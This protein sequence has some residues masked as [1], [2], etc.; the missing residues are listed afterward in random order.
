MAIGV[1]GSGLAPR[2]KTQP[3]PPSAPKL[4][5]G[6]VILVKTQRFSGPCTLSRTPEPK[7]APATV[8]DP[9]ILLPQSSTFLDTPHPTPS[10]ADTLTSEQRTHNSQRIVLS[11]TLPGPQAFSECQEKREGCGQQQEL[12]T[13]TGCSS[14]N[15][16][17][18]TAGAGPGIGG[19]SAGCMEGLKGVLVLGK[20][21]DS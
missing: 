19:G 4:S 18:I 1:P 11:T 20:T 5:P 7:S 2:V 12:A 15:W 3:P 21:E 13:G 9:G 14:P 8:R 16:T 17:D 10:E 6:F